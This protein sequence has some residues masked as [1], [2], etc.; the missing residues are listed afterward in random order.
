M[1]IL[2]EL[3]TAGQTI[4]LV[5]HEDYIAEHAMRVVRLRDGIIESDVT[6]QARVRGAS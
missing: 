5:T 6:S 3:H 1:T 4:I 2:D